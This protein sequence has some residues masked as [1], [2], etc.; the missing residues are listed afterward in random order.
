MLDH[1]FQLVLPET[2]KY[3]HIHIIKENIKLFLKALGL[4]L[5]G[6]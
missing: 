1:I 3:L 2:I 5:L 6:I 4:A